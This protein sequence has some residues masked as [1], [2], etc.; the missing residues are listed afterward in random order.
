[1]TLSEVGR[2]QFDHN[3]ILD[4]AKARIRQRH[5]ELELFLDLMPEVFTYPE[6]HAA[7]ERALGRDVDRSNLYKRAVSLLAPG[8]LSEPVPV[9]KRGRGQPPRHYNLR[10]VLAALGESA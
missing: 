9:T 7:Y 1:V 2:L 4:D 3:R 10:H 5:E 6:F 8:E